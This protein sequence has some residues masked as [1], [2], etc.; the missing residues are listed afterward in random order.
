LGARQSPQH[1]PLLRGDAQ[2]IKGLCALGVQ[3]VGGLKKTK[4]KPVVD[5]LNSHI[6]FGTLIG[7]GAVPGVR[8]AAIVNDDLAKKVEI[9]VFK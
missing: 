3:G 9:V 1:R 8:T 7:H 6:F 5:F 4:K 2:A